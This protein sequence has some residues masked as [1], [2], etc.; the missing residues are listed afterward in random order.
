LLK[1]FQVF[2]NIMVDKSIWNLSSNVIFL[3]LHFTNWYFYKI[4]NLETSNQSITPFYLKCIKYPF[5]QNLIM[6]KF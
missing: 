3:T 1:S 4:I 2:E 5:W 6:L